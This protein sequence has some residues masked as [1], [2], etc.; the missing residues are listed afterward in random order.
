MDMQ[1]KMTNQPKKTEAELDAE[2]LLHLLRE[3][4]ESNKAEDIVTIDLEGKSSIADYLLIATGRSG[5]HVNAIADYVLRAAKDA[6]M[7]HLTTEGLSSGDWVLIDAGDVIIH[8]FRSEVREY[9]NLE[10]IWSVSVAAKT[11]ET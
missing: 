9:Y 6:G 1:S 3:E 2:Q 10:K 5:R 11:A 4:L 8:L 7:G